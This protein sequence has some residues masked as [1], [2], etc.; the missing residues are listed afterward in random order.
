MANLLTRLVD[1]QPCLRLS[2]RV[3]TPSDAVA[4]IDA[5]KPDVTVLDLMLDGGSGFDVLKALEGRP[6]PR[7]NV[8]VLTNL[9]GEPYR[10]AAIR[11]GATHFFDKSSEIPVMLGLLIGLA[12]KRGQDDRPPRA[13]HGRA[14]P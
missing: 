4:A 5:L 2:G 7:P 9:A 10:E 1:E 11:L 6:G 8:V 3:T 12:E 13:G 14:L